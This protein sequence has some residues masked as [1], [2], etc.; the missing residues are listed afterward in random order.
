MRS[1]LH[2]GGADLALSRAE[3]RA[4]LDEY[5]FRPDVR[6]ARRVLLLPPD[7]TRLYSD[8]GFLTDHLYRCFRAAGAEVAVLPA[9]GTHAAM[10]RAQQTLLFGDGLPPDAFRVHDFRRDVLTLGTVPG[11]RLREFSGGRVDYDVPVQVNRLLVEGGFDRIVSLGQV[12]P[13]EVAGMANHAKNLFVGVGGADFIHRSHFLGAVC[14]I[15][16]VLGQTDSP[17]RRLFDEAYARFGGRLSAPVDF[18]LTVVGRRRD[19]DEG[20][21]NP[22]DEVHRPDSGLV[23]RGL[24]IGPDRSGFEAAAALSRTVNL[25]RVSPAPAKAVA[26]LPPEEFASCWL[27]NK[28]IYRLRCAMADDGELLILAPGVETFGEDP[29]IDRLIRRHGYRGTAAILAAVKT[30]PELADNLSAA[31]T[32]IHGSTEGRFRVTY[33]T[34]P[35]KLSRAAVEAAGFGWMDVRAALARY[36]PARLAEG[37]NAVEGERVFYVSNPALGLWTR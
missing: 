30:D 25:D 24:Y 16:S 5:F 12:V 31:A 21:G 28:A 18:V 35:S 8:A 1:S 23:V 17:V 37:W 2:W 32:L 33:A 10:T 3:R 14:G 22:E 26:Y 6:A 27:G 11:E 34:D 29:E 13:H 20:T 9:L 36:D 7:H 4:A 15:E 19:D